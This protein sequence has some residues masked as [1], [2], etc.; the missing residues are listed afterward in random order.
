MLFSH[1]LQGSVL[2]S[3]LY[4]NDC[5]PVSRV[6]MNGIVKRVFQNWSSLFFKVVHTFSQAMIGLG[7][8][9]ILLIIKA[10]F[11]NMQQK[12]FSQLFTY[13]FPSVWYLPGALSCMHTYEIVQVSVYQ[14]AS[15]N[16]F[17]TQESDHRF[18]SL[19]D[20]YS[21]FFIVESMWLLQVS[22]GPDKM[23]QDKMAKLA[24]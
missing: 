24:N 18:S 13:H 2:C 14:S 7:I 23:V 5:N 16:C 6:E 19:G 10:F 21:F 9:V 15:H 22:I 11:G 20:F 3:I 1:S 12:I 4:W 17:W 8:W